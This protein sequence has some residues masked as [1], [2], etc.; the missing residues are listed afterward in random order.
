MPS[1]NIEIDGRTASATLE[2]NSSA[3][4]LV[5]LLKEGALTLHMRDYGSM[6][7]VGPL[8]RTLPR[9][10]RPTR[11]GPGDMILYEGDNL[12]IYYDTNSWNFTRLGRLDGMSDDEIRSFLGS[13]SVDVTL[14]L[15]L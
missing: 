1:I 10:D 5:E 9:N 14:S 11:T 15:P 13:G 12:V 2:D 6:E 7:K 3:V 4:A 8:G